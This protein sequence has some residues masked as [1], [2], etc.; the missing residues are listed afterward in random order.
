[1]V[2]NLLGNLILRVRPYDYLI[3][4]HIIENIEARRPK[5]IGKLHCSLMQAIDKLI[6]TGFAKILKRRPQ[7]HSS[8]SS[9]HFRGVHHAI[10]LIAIA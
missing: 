7:L 5:L 6:D 4:H 8:G 3:K 9:R 10:A 2:K 1:M